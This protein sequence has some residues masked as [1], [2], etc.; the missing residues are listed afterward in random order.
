VTDSKAVNG[1]GKKQG[2]AKQQELQMKML[3]LESDAC[4]RV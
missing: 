3:E 1:K 2:I 4:K